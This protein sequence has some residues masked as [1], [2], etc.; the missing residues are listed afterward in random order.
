VITTSYKFSRTAIAQEPALNGTVSVPDVRMLQP[1]LAKKMLTNYGLNCQTFGTGTMVI[2]QTPE[3]GKKIEKGEVV[4]LILNG[5]SL[6]SSDGM[7][8]VPDV[9]GM[10]IRRAMNRLV[11]DEFEIKVQGSGVVTQQIPSAG[12]RARSGSSILLLCSPRSV[13]QAT[14]Y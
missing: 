9:R 3:P 4:S 7:I 1:S 2:K 14:L 6:V 8:T 10:S 11:S 13:L 5:E 12:E